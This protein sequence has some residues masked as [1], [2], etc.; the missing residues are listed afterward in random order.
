MEK[1]HTWEPERA[2]FSKTAILDETLRDGIQGAQVQQEPAIE[3][4]KTLLELMERLGIDLAMIGF[5]ASKDDSLVLAQHIT[6]ARLHLKACC[7]A[8]TQEA[9]IAMVA[10]IAQKTGLPMEAALFVGASPIR[11]EVEQWDIETIIQWVRQS[12]RL[13]KREGI[14]VLFATEDTSRSNPATLKRI[15]RTAMDEGADSLCI[16]DTV[17][18]CTPGSAANLVKF[19]RNEVMEGH[20]LPLE[21][22]GHNDKGMG[23]A[24][25]MRAVEEGVWRVHA[26]ALGLGERAGNVPMHTLVTNLHLNGAD[27]L[28]PQHLMR[29]SEHAASMCGTIIPANEPII[30]RYAFSTEA[31]IHAAAIGKAQTPAERD[32]VYSAVPATLVGRE[33]EILVGPR[34][35]TANVLLLAQH[36]GMRIPSAPAIQRIL[37]ITKKERRQLSPEEIK[38]LL[39]HAEKEPA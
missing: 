29:Y 22:H 21:W 7:L 39:Q 37:D 11:M 15:Y 14:T 16:T 34:S 32:T 1:I 27:D 2:D 25:A 28:R 6:D 10:D 20:A 3:Q 18:V 4:K 17:G 31:G 30:G 8:R 33:Q 5:P 36:Y 13:A 38:E 26:T 24:N 35:G 9:D 23:V 19:F 12:V